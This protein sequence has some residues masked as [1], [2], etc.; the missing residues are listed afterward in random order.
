MFPL[1][2]SNNPDKKSPV[3]LNKKIITDSEEIT[4]LLKTI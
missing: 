1:D 4:F 3:F 2:L